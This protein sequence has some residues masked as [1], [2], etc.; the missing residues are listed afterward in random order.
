MEF[1]IK[2]SVLD[3]LFQEKILIADLFSLMVTEKFDLSFLHKL[4]LLICIYNFGPFWL[5]F[6]L[7]LSYH[8]V[9]FC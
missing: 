9:S 1:P 2:P 5:S 7:F 6:Q 8:H 3:V 4:V